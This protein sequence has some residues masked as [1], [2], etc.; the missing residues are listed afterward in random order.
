MIFSVYVLCKENQLLLAMRSKWRILLSPLTWQGDPPPPPSSPGGVTS[1]HPALSSEY[2]CYPLWGLC[3]TG[4]VV[5]ATWKGALPPP[6]TLEVTVPQTSFCATTV[7]VDG[8]DL[9]CGDD[10]YLYIFAPN[11]VT[12][13][14]ARCRFGYSDLSSPGLS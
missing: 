5:F 1:P 6:F 4:Q 13:Q 14:S 2:S 10:T 12:A 8:M 3:Q 11:F 9:G 7:S